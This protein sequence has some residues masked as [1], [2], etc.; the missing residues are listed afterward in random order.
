M[1]TNVVIVT[2]LPED[3][4]EQ[5]VISSLHDHD[6][7]IQTTCPQLI[8]RRLVSGTPGL[9]LPCAYEIV[10][11]RSFGE[12]R[13]GLTLTNVAEGVDALV[14]GRTPTGSMKVRSE[15]RVRAGKLQEVVDIECNLITK[16]I[17]KKNVE[18]GHPEFHQHLFTVAVRS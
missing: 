12:M 4:S 3:T 8:S 18:K 1:P 11:T 5:A 10:D 6:I 16:M 14:E 9:D 13:F 2:P 17:V 15:W 7:Y